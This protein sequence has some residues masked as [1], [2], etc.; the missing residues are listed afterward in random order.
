MGHH[1]TKEGKFKSDKY[2]WCPEGFF[3]LKLTDPVAQDAAIEYALKTED[4]GLAA[5]LIQAVANIRK[6]SGS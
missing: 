1:L 3:A 2:S 4:T 6:E 5:D